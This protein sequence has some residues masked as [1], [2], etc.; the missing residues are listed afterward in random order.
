MKQVLTK[1]IIRIKR[2]KKENL[3][4]NNINYY[5]YLFILKKINSLFN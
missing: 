5:K 1:K 3:N 2:R 4:L